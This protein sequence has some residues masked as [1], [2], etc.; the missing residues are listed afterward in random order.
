MKWIKW[1][2]SGRSTTLLQTETSQ[3]LLSGLSWKCEHTTAEQKN[4][5]LELSMIK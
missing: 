3:Q 2:R 4:N 5:A 1:I